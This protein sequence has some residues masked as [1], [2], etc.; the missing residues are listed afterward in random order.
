MAGVPRDTYTFSFG[1]A[2]LAVKLPRNYYDSID[3]KLGFTSVSE[4]A[5]R[6]LIVLPTKVAIRSGALLQ[7]G[8]LYLQG[9]KL[10][11]SKILCPPARAH[12]AMQEIEGDTYRS[13]TIR[14][15]Y[16]TLQRNLG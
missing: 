4:S 14:S 8:I 3:T 9:T 11:R 16:F 6:G 2:T 10:V 5:A 1:E 13:F 15:A 7:L 12:T